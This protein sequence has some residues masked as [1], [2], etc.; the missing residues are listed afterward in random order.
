MLLPLS[1]HLFVLELLW[2]CCSLLVCFTSWPGLMLWESGRRMWWC[3]GPSSR[4]SGGASKSLF[5]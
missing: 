1:L 3:A 2:A 5:G 4:A